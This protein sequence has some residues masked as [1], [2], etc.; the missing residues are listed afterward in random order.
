[1]ELLHVHYFYCMSDVQ[2]GCQPGPFSFAKVQWENLKTQISEKAFDSLSPAFL[3]FTYWDGEDLIAVSSQEELDEALRLLEDGGKLDLC[4][5]LK[6]PTEGKY[7]VSLHININFVTE[8]MAERARTRGNYSRASD[9]FSDFM[10]ASKVGTGKVKVVLEA[11]GQTPSSPPGVAV[12]M[13]LLPGI[14]FDTPESQGTE[15]VEPAEVAETGELDTRSLRDAETGLW[16]QSCPEAPARRLKSGCGSL[17]Q[18]TSGEDLVDFTSR[19]RRLR[20]LECNDVDSLQA[21]RSHGSAEASTDSFDPPNKRDCGIRRSARRPDTRS[22]PREMQKE[23]SHSPAAPG[24]RCD[25]CGT[26]KFDARKMKHSDSFL[27]ERAFSVYMEKYGRLLKKWLPKYIAKKTARC[28][29]KM[30][31]KDRDAASKTLNGPPDVS[32]TMRVPAHGGILCSICNRTIVGNRYRCCTCTDYHLCEGCERIK[33]HLHDSSHVFLKFRSEEVYTCNREQV[34]QT[35]ELPVCND[36][37]EERILLESCMNRNNDDD[38]EEE[39]EDDDIQ[40]RLPRREGLSIIPPVE[41]G[42]EQ[43]DDES[44]DEDLDQLEKARDTALDDT[45]ARRRRREASAVKGYY[46]RVVRNA[47]PQF[48]ERCRRQENGFVKPLTPE[49]PVC[50]DDE[51]ERI[52]LESCMNRNNDDDNEEEEEDDDIQGR[53]PRREGLSII[54]PVESG[55]EQEDDESDDED[56]DQLEK[57][58]DTALDDTEARRRRREASAVKVRNAHPQFGEHCRRQENGF[59]KPLAFT[60]LGVDTD[61]EFP[62]EGSQEDGGG[63]PCGR[64]YARDLNEEHNTCSSPIPIPKNEPEVLRSSPIAILASSQMAANSMTNDSQKQEIDSISVISLLSEESS[65]DEEY[66]VVMPVCFD[67]SK[68]LSDARPQESGPLDLTAHRLQVLLH[69]R[70]ELKDAQDVP[71]PDKSL[72]V[73]KNPDTVKLSDIPESHEAEPEEG[74]VLLVG[75]ADGSEKEADERNQGNESDIQNTSTVSTIIFSTEGEEEDEE[76]GNMEEDDDE[77]EDKQEDDDDKQEDDDD[78]Q[79]DDDDKQEEDDDKQEDDNKQEDDD[80]KQED[81]DNK[82]EDDDDKQE[83]NDKQEDDAKEDNDEDRDD[84]R[85]ESGEEDYEDSEE[86]DSE[87]EDSLEKIAHWLNRLLNK[88]VPEGLQKVY[89]EQPGVDHRPMENFYLRQMLDSM[90]TSTASAAQEPEDC[91]AAEET[92]VEGNAHSEQQGAAAAAASGEDCDAQESNLTTTTS[93]GLGDSKTN[94]EAFTPGPQPDPTLPGE[95]CDLLLPETGSYKF[96]TPDYKFRESTWQPSTEEYVPK[97]SSYTLPKSEY[98][99]PKSIYMGPQAQVPGGVGVGGE[100]SGAV[101]RIREMG[102]FNNE[103]ILALLKKHEGDMLKV[104]NELCQETDSDWAQH[105]H[106]LPQ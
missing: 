68:P 64:T 10:G 2:Q 28:V 25:Q 58:R 34:P 49:L 71:S 44:D 60:S 86:E 75:N 61:E 78:K 53:L 59:V 54:P 83:N 56:L 105:R 67:T 33:G 101:Q 1:M 87:E 4:V 84:K 72:P 15:T 80:N 35:P 7:F 14:T 19:M 43:E 47:H 20:Q 103:R 77:E 63:L 31:A 16:M 91:E 30:L 26:T 50:N 39:E 41:S 70:G 23:S 17:N 89:A 102:Y 94:E 12:W 74:W 98:Q 22:R 6:S 37:E 104:V 38:N 11:V 21:E 96:S 69:G 27:T 29:V 88:I 99:M 85:E 93:E 55:D 3:E 51:E 97:K 52:L 90:K 8:T 48:R 13:Y 79:E 46:L 106:G 36:D 42:D 81:D 32:A 100:Y 62:W 5:D 9:C 57:A 66:T 95:P 18:L 76:E 45:E 24:F 73:T 92:D 82:Q 65:S 40:G